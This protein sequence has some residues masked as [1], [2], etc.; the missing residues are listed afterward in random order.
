MWWLEDDSRLSTS[1][2]E[3]IAQ[4]G[5]Q[6][7]ISAASIW[8]LAIKRAACRYAGNDLLGPARA[9]GFTVIAMD[10]EHAK[11]AGELP[12][13]H[14]DPFDRMLVAQALIEDRVLVS[15]DELLPRY[16]VPVLW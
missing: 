6:A 2:G 15:S 4:A 16:G 1:A 5:D 12:P 8:E 7:V 11:L 13:H 14:R 9:A 3:A 10:G